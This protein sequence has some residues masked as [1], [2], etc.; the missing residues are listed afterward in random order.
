MPREPEGRGRRV[1]LWTVATV[2]AAS[3]GLLLSNGLPG[4]WHRLFDPGDKPFAITVREDRSIYSQVPAIA[5]RFAYALPLPL[6]C[7]TGAGGVGCPNDRALQPPSESCADWKPWVEGLGGVDSTVSRLRV[8]LTG[9]TGGTVVIEGVDV[10][11]RRVPRPA[12][13]TFVGCE[14]RASGT[15]SVRE[16]ELDL[17]AGGPGEF[18]FPDDDERRGGASG[19]VAITLNEGEVEIFDVVAYAGH[20]YCEWRATIRG[21]SGDVEFRTP[22]TGREGAPFVTY[23]GLTRPFLVWRNGGWSRLA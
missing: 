5:E 7:F 20:C 23:P 3:I 17:D 1:A 6:K 8:N 22:V 12:I 11:T 18:V 15:V 19:P 9:G 16:V 14:G 2:A 10:E 4:V 21:V 13:L